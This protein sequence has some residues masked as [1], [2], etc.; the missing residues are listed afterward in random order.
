[1]MIDTVT[2]EQIRIAQEKFDQA[3]KNSKN[4]TESDKEKL[5]RYE[6]EL[7]RMI[8]AS[9]SGPFSGMTKISKN[10]DKEKVFNLVDGVWIFMRCSSW[11]CRSLQ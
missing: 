10:L 8:E 9:E 6:K 1:M 3:L 11:L 5:S 7:E 4:N 2:A